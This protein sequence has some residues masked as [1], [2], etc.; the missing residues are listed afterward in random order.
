MCQVTVNSEHV[1]F[2]VEVHP[3]ADF[4]NCAMGALLEALPV[5]LKSL[6]TC[7]AGGSST[8]GYNPGNRS[9]CN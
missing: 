6:M 2:E 5:A 9:R 4:M 3:T 1:K 7:L 8:S